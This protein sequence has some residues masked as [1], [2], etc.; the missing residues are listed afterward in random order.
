MSAT[1]EVICYK[2]KVL[3]NQEN[4]LMLRV[5]KDRKRKFLSIGISIKPEFWDF[6]KNKPKKSCPHKEEIQQIILERIKEYQEQILEYKTINK[7]FTA[8]SLIEKVSNPVKAKTVK[9]TFELFIKQ[10]ITANRLKYALMFKCTL[11]SLIKFNGHLDIYFSDIDVSWLKR[12]EFWL[13]GQNLALNTL[14]TRFRI[15]RVVFNFAIEEKIVKPEYYPFNSYKV[16]KLQRKTAK[17]SI[18]KSEI[19]EVLNYKGKTDYERLAIDL[20]TFS[21]LTAGINF[22][23]IANLTKNNLMDNRLVYDRKK[24]K[25]QIIVPLQPKALELI[26]KYSDSDN[27]YLF[28]I[29]SSFHKTEQKKANRV[30]KVIGKVNK[31]LKEIGKELKIPIDLTTYVARHSFATVL[32]RSGVSTSII[33]ESLGHSSEKVTQIYLEDAKLNRFTKK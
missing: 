18:L 8:T 11:N 26:N 33:S 28:P 5:T 7:E 15:L 29:L 13:Q 2:S 12:Y 9:S 10:L 19:L 24:T 32:K 3:A 20:F 1:I 25:K 17:R 21:Y 30:H 6:E 23:D 31:A 14:G 4:P 22:V 16:S 27:L